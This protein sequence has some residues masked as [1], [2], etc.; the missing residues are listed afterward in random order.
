VL[1]AVVRLTLLVD[2]AVVIDLFVRGSDLRAWLHGLCLEADIWPLDLFSGALGVYHLGRFVSL[3]E[4]SHVL[5]YNCFYLLLILCVV[6]RL[7]KN[8]VDDLA[9]ICTE[10]LVI[11]GGKVMASLDRLIDVAGFVARLSIGL[12]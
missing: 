12:H 6:V 9:E 4:A 2:L 1:S 5:A 7:D 8:L 10:F 11:S 3:L